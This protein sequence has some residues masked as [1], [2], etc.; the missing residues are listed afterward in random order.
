MPLIANKTTKS[1]TS[2]AITNLRVAPALLERKDGNKKILRRFGEPG[3][4]NRP[5]ALYYSF[6]T[7]RKS[8]L[9]FHRQVCLAVFAGSCCCWQGCC[10]GASHLAAALLL[11]LPWESQALLSSCALPVFLRVNQ[12][13]LFY[14]LTVSSLSHDLLLFRW[15][16]SLTTSQIPQGKYKSAGLLSLF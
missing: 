8:Q 1:F 15:F 3:V 6:T 11:Q 4:S 10:R 16:S 13:P 2:N 7:V 14:K 12:R 9:L 5:A